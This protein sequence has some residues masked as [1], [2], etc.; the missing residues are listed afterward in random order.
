MAA[1]HYLIIICFEESVGEEK[2]RNKREKEGGKALIL[3]ILKQIFAS[4]KRGKHLLLKISMASFTNQ[5]WL[6]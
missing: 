2:E 1:N 4:E 3:K 5:T 6:F